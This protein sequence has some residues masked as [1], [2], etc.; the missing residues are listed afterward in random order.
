VA[1]VRLRVTPRLPSRER[2][3]VFG[4]YFSYSAFIAWSQGFGS[5]SVSK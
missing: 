1:F 3:M 4:R 2:A 5:R